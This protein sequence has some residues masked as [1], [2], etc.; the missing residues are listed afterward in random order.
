MFRL[1][2]GYVNVR[3]CGVPGAK[4]DVAGTGDLDRS[5]RHGVLRS[6]I[7]SDGEHGALLLIGGSRGGQ[8][9]GVGRRLE[10]RSGRRQVADIH[11]KGDHSQ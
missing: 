11:G 8:R 7:L 10:L 1:A 6:D 3:D 2:I 4:L 5:S 9:R